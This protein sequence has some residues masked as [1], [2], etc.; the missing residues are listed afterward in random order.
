[1]ANF[2][3]PLAIPAEIM[4]AVFRQAR[5][6]FPSECCGWLSGPADGNSVDTIHPAVNAQDSDALVAVAGRD[7]ERAYAFNFADTRALDDSFAT[8]HPARIIYH[9]HP[10]GRA[11]FSETDR[12]VATQPA[13]WGGGPVFP[14]QQM[15]VGIDGERVVEA[16]LFDWFDDDGWSMFGISG[17]FGEIARYSGADI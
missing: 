11:Y 3:H 14:V 7:S 1:M 8:Q 16:A 10:N 17:G 13:V 9:S 5:E 6:S 2:A 12:E 4:Q 15:V